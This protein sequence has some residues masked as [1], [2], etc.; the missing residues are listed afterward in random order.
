MWAAASASAVG[1]RE[2]RVDPPRRNPPLA[3]AVA[4]R[5]GPGSIARQ[6]PAGGVV[7]GAVRDGGFVA[8]FAQLTLELPAM[9]A[10]MRSRDEWSLGQLAHR[11]RA[12]PGFDF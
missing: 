4:G 10:R 12:A 6:A 9:A 3:T 11:D 1:H 8:P 5:S 2:V 7:I